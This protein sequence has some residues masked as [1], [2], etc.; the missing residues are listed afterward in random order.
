MNNWIQLIGGGFA[1]MDAPFG[2]HPRDKERAHEYRQAARDAHLDWP[3]IQ[4]H[5]DAYAAKQD[6][7]TAKRFEELAR[8][9]KFMSN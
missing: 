4:G 9:R 7:S 8:V 3:S 6:W 1:H 2:A 5:F